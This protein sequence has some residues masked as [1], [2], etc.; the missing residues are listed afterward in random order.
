VST[1]SRWA[2]RWRAA[3]VLAAVILVVW[4][5]R[6]SDEARVAEVMDDVARALTQSTLDPEGGRSEQL[7]RAFVHAFAPEARISAP[8]LVLTDA[9]PDAL[10]A[11]ARRV[12]A[13]F[14]STRVQL[15]PPT[16]EVAASGREASAQLQV[17]ASASGPDIGTLTD[18]REARVE[19][20]ET[21]AGWRIVSVALTAPSHDE[22]EARP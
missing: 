15:G 22:P 20:R 2:W 9:G 17:V 10:A 14:D 3:A 7:N 5:W 16:I 19:L 21:D 1:D 6:G 12:L 13:G 18:V 8:D 11:A 4:L